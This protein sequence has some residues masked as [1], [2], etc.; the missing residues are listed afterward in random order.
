M[1]KFTQIHQITSKMRINS[2]PLLVAE[3]FYVS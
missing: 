1:K 3:F 2:I